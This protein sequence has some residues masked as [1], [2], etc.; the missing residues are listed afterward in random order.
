MLWDGSRAALERDTVSDSGAPWTCRLQNGR[1]LVE[2]A[3]RDQLPLQSLD[4]PCFSVPWNVC[5]ALVKRLLSNAP[6]AHCCC[7][8]V[9][10]ARGGGMPSVGIMT[11]SARES[12]LPRSVKQTQS[13]LERMKR[14]AHD[15]L[16]SLSSCHLFKQLA[17]PLGCLPDAS[18]N[19]KDA[20]SLA[21]CYTL[22]VT[23]R[24]SVTAC[25]YLHTTNAHRILKSPAR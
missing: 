19:A 24:H 11:A 3:P 18:L 17:V 16:C 25:H 10:P 1:M 14:N 15:M 8:R 5:N 2:K 4:R 22:H 21:L 23:A 13:H 7:I 6:R 20:L 12:A 9:E